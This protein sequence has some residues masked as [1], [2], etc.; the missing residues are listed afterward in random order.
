MHYLS[1]RNENI[2]TNASTA[3]LEGLSADGGLYTPSE[4]PVLGK[5]ELALLRTMNYEKR[6]AWILACYL[7]DYTDEELLSI[8]QSAYLKF[9]SGNV[10]P[11]VSIGENTF[12]L[13]L[14]RGP[15]SAFKDVALSIMPQ[16]LTSAL[17]KSGSDDE[18][19]ILVATS[20]DTG[21]A[22]L[23]GYTDLEGTKIIVFYP[24]E[25]I[26][27]V[28]KLQMSTHVGKNT[29]VCGIKGNFDDAQTGVKKLFL[30]IELREKL[31]KHGIR[32]SSANSINWGRLVPQIVYYISAYCDMLNSGMIDTCEKVNVCV[33]TGNFGN[34]LA[35]YY[36]KKMGLPIKML[37]CASNTNR[38]LDEFIRTGIYNA[39]RKFDKTISPSMDIIVSSNVE[40]LL[41]EIL[42]HSGK[43]ISKLMSSLNE[44]Y[45]FELNSDAHN[46]LKESF[47]S[48]WCSEAE[49]KD[50]INEYYKSG[51]YLPDT[52]TA[53]ALNVLNKYKKRTG[54]QTKTLVA[55]TAS[56]F[57]FA[58]D[59]LSAIG[60]DVS[61][62][63]KAI[64]QL[65]EVSGYPVP[66][67]LVGLNNRPILHTRVIECA[68]MRKTSE[69]LLGIHD[70]K[71]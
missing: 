21:K 66:G 27:P 55:S 70:D 61:D 11:V 1:T 8:S 69:F 57:K 2:V 45:C 12:M 31:A 41:F 24:D 44:S 3:I 17:H 49:T 33:P 71:G 60:F 15:T 19:C 53:V 38:V 46:I 52:H 14:F 34:I 68:D 40:R 47:V 4:I 26:S 63:L 5:N 28:Q 50:T 42:G 10:A 23:E 51:R 20:G 43:D 64:D 18:I 16:L 25:G 62:D 22:A 59:V 29:F 37:I 35:A 6:A 32:L 7:N 58:S 56:P 67:P 65:S 36:A 48:D 13:E 39:N 30:D 9:E 54:D